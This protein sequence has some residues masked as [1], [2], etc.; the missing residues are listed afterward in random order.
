MCPFSLNFDGIF[1]LFLS[2][3]YC[4]FYKYGLFIQLIHDCVSCIHGG[5]NSQL[6]WISWLLLL[7]KIYKRQSKRKQVRII[8]L[9]SLLV[10]GVMDFNS[11]VPYSG[12]EDM[13]LSYICEPFHTIKT[14][15]EQLTFSF[16]SI[17][18]FHI[19]APCLLFLSSGHRNPSVNA[20]TIQ[21]TYF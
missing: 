16:Q 6:N 20:F 2:H 14:Y 3:W 12:V 10:L 15:R 21:L 5:H 9:I 8:F 13:A 7:I 4:L 19:R 17:S 1:V 18:I 11:L